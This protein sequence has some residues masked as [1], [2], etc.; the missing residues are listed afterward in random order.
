MDEPTVMSSKNGNFSF[1]RP[2][3][4]METKPEPVTQIKLLQLRTR[5]HSFSKE[6]LSQFLQNK[7][8]VST[9]EKFFN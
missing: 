9:E 4:Q 7:G 2:E 8:C 1:T 6:K 5:K 3:S